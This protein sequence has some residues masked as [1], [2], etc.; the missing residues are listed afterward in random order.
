MRALIIRVRSVSF[1]VSFSD[2]RHIP[3]STA[4]SVLAAV[5]CM[6]DDTSPLSESFLGVSFPVVVS[7]TWGAPALRSGCSLTATPIDSAAATPLATALHNSN[8]TTATVRTVL[9]LVSISVV[10]QLKGSSSFDPF[11]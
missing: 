1:S 6:N 9:M 11:T 2:A 3:E 7:F 8:A 4:P 10:L 5:I